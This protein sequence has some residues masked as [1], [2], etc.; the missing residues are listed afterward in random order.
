MS[1]RDMEKEVGREG[2]N[3]R[4]LSLLVVKMMQTQMFQ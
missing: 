3:G 2:V 4:F 1:D